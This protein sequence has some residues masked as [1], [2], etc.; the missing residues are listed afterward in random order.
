M[1]YREAY[2]TGTMAGLARLT[3]P[4]TLPLID[5]R[6]DGRQMH[7]ALP[8]R[9]P[10]RNRI[11]PQVAILDL[12]REVIDVLHLPA[13]GMVILRERQIHVGRDQRAP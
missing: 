3:F 5:H 4:S 2:Y 8:A 12:E 1:G 7:Q 13:I 11:A 9:T 6:P 10:R